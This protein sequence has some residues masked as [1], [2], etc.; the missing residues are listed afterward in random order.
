MSHPQPAWRDGTDSDAPKSNDQD[1]AIQEPAH[2]PLWLAHLQPREGKEGTN[3]SI[4]DVSVT[5]ELDKA[6]FE[7]LSR[8]ARST[9][10]KIAD[11]IHAAVQREI[12]AKPHVIT[13]IHRWNLHREDLDVAAD[14]LG[15][16]QLSDAEWGQVGTR[17]FRRS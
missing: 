16:D 4:P 3:T 15:V 11:V 10:S 9:G 1:A 13:L 2:V 17:R 12:G 14:A 6:D 7:A 8:K 5:V